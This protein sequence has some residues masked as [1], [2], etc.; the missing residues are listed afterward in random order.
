MLNQLRAELTAKV[1]KSQDEMGRLLYGPGM[2]GNKMAQ[3]VPYFFD[4]VFALRVEKN[5]DGEVSRALQCQPDGQWSAKDRSGKL[6]AFEP[7]NLGD[8]FR[9]AR[10]E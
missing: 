8:V 6:N 3:A 7:P 4:Q 10:G 9:K 1:E 2:P 5:Q